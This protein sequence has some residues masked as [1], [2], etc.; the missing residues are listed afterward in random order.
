[1]AMDQFLVFSSS[2]GIKGETKDKTYGSK[3]GIDILAWSWGL[4][5]SG[6][7]H[8]GPGQGSGKSSFQDISVTKYVDLASAK[9]MYCCATGTHL[10]EADLIVR[11]AG[12]TPLEYVT[13]KLKDLLVSSYST[14]GSGGEDKLTEN[15]S[16]NFATV[17][18]EYKTQD[19]TGK[20]GKEKGN[21]TYDIPSNSKD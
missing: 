17:E 14:G 9:L 19:A 18:I 2:D 1:M 5:N 12:G 3:N 4:S 8:M 11:K 21:F 7:A 20:E 15:V 13:I 16:L 10:K 6:S